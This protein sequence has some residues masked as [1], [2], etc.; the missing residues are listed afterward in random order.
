MPRPTICQ[1]LALERTILKNT[2][3]TTSGTS[4]PVSSMSTEIAMCG[5]PVFCEK[6]S[7]SD[8]AYS[9]LKV[10]VRANSPRYSGV[11]D[12]ESFLDEFGVPLVLGKDDGLAQPV[13]ARHLVA[14]LHQQGQ[15]F[16]HRVGVEQPLVHRLG[17]HLVGRFATFLVPLQRVPL[18]FSSSL[19]SS[20]RMPWRWNFSGTE[21]ALGGAR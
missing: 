1:N 8:C 2:R 18:V 13:A 5:A 15:H 16:V 21:I 17:A 12:V 19:S 6:A 9:V 11:V 14:A 10:M 3:F 7:M 4:M 20:Y